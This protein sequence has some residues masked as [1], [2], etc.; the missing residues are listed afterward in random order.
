MDLKI[1]ELVFRIHGSDSILSAAAD[2][3]RAFQHDQSEADFTVCLDELAQQT[4]DRGVEIYDQNSYRV[5]IHDLKMD[6]DL[7]RRKCRVWIAEPHAHRMLVTL[8]RNLVLILSLR[9]NVLVLHASACRVNSSIVFFSG[10]SG[11]GKST[12]LKAIRQD[13]EPVLD[14]MVLL[15]NTNGTWH[16]LGAPDWSGKYRGLEESLPLSAGF[17][18]AR[19]PKSV[20]EELSVRERL[21]GLINVPDAFTRLIDLQ[22]LIT[23]MHDMVCSTACRRLGFHPDTLCFRDVAGYL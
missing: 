9:R 6:V 23:E 19:S 13:V 14:D 3:F 1:A 4:A 5:E 17:I 22:T 12:V 8:F 20:V 2:L 11:A 7:D 16:S 21:S 18:L 10:P 15:G